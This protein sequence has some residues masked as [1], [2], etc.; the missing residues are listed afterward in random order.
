MPG[1]VSPPWA[2]CWYE[3]SRTASDSLSHDNRTTMSHGPSTRW[4]KSGSFHE[5][6][7]LN[8]VLRIHGESVLHGRTDDDGFRCHLSAL[9]W[10]ITQICLLS[11]PIIWEEIEGDGAGGGSGTCR[12]IGS[13][14]ILMFTTTCGKD[15]S[16]H[17][18]HWALSVSPRTDGFRNPYKNVYE[19][20]PL[21]I[22]TSTPLLNVWEACPA[23]CLQE[24]QTWTLMSETCVETTEPLPADV[25]FE[26]VCRHVYTQ[27][28]SIPVN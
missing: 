16:S 13:K 11:P 14:R 28:W 25:Y 4:I 26:R 1:D 18:W 20:H 2:L 5:A 23:L 15:H 10:Q 21:L 3:R 17:T 24:E 27:I 7:R 8:K 12:L 9:G 6:G 19:P 22:S